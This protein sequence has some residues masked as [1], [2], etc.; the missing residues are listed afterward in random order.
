MKKRNFF[1]RM[2]LAG[3]VVALLCATATSNAL[4]APKT[5]PTCNGWADTLQTVPAYCDPATQGPGYVCTSGAATLCTDF[6]GKGNYAN[7][8]LPSGPIDTTASGFT[9]VHGGSGY[10]SPVAVTVTDYFTGTVANP[11]TGCLASVDGNGTITGITCATAGSGYMAPVVSIAGAGGSGSGA[12]VDAK[13]SAAGPLVGGIRKFQDNLPDL[14]GAVASPD[15]TTFPGSDYYE[16]ALVKTTTQMHAD[17]PLTPVVGYVQFPSGSSS[18]S[19]TPVK[20]YQY[21]GP[22]ILAQKDKPVRVKFTNCLTPGSG[23]D[24]FIPVD[25]TYMGAGAGPTT[26]STDPFFCADPAN[27]ASCFQQNRATLHLHGGNTPWISDGTPHQW[28]VPYGDTSATFKRGDSTQFVP[29]MFFDATGKVSAVP[30]PQCS[31]AITTNCYPNAPPAGL[32]SDPGLG[33]MTFYWTNQQGGRLMFYHDHA[34][35]TTRLN[36]YAGEAAGYLVADP[37]QE[38]KLKLLNVPGTIT[39]PANPADLVNN[40]L[41]HLIP[42][43]IQ[44]KTFVPSAPQLL[45]Q[46]PTWIWGTG[47]TAVTTGNGN[48]VNGDL[49]FPHVYPPNQNPND[50]NGGPNNPL[51]ANGFG[52]WDYGVWFVPGQNVLS[53]AGTGPLGPNTAVTIP[54]TSS[55]FPGVLLEPTEANQYQGGCPI[56][57]NPSGTPEGFMDTPLV[58]GKAYPVLNVNPEAYRFQILSAGNDRSWNLQLYAADATGNDVAMLPAATPPLNGLPLC[59]IINQPTQPG[60]GMGLTSAILDTAGEPINGTGLL[61]NCWP[62]YGQSPGIPIKQFHWPDDGR[63][64]GVP[65]PRQAGPAIVQIAT[66]GGLLPA[67]VVIPS[68]PVNY[69][70]NTRSV[71]I[72]NISTHGLWIGPAERA[73]V[74]IDFSKFAGKTLILYNDAPAPAPAFDMRLDYFTGAPDETSTGGAPT[75]LPGYGPNTRTVMK[76]VVGATGTGQTAFKVAPLAAPTGLPAL[77][78]ATQPTVVVPEPAYPAGAGHSAT[79]NYVQ[80][81]QATALTFQS[82]GPTAGTSVVAQVKVTPNGSGYSSST[83]V[84]ID[85]PACTPAPGTCVTALATP[86]IGAGGAIIGINV[87]NV[88]AGYAASVPNVVLTDHGIGGTALLPTC[89]GSGQSACGSGASAT[90]IMAAR[91]PFD[92][93]AIQE[94]FTL[95]YGRMNATLGT[96]IPFT[97]FNNQ[98]TLPFGYTDWATEIVQKDTPQLWYL[99]HNGVDTHFIHFHL[100]NVQV[101]NR[102]GWDGTVRPIDQNELGWKDTV[103]MNPLENVLLAIKPITPVVPFPVPD[104]IRL[105]DPTKPAGTSPDMAISGID[106]ATGNALANGQVNQEVNFGWEYVWH[107][108]ILGHEEN[109]MMR[110]MIYQVPPS[111]PANLTTNSA[112]QLTWTDNSASESAFILQKDTVNTFNSGALATFTVTGANSTGF[113]TLGYGQT[114]T[115]L[116]ASASCTPMYYRVQAQD[117]FLPQSPLTATPGTTFQ[118]ATVASDWTAPVL[119]GNAPVSITTASLPFG[120]AGTAYNATLAAAGGSGPYTWAITAGK[121]AWLSINS[122]TGALTG[123]PPNTTGSPFTLA[124]QVTDNCGVVVSKNLSLTVYPPLSITTS[125]L[126]AGTVNTLYTTTTLTATGGSGTYVNWAV[127]GGALPAGLSLNATTGAISGTPTAP[128]NASITFQVT[129]SIGL[130]ATRSLTLTVNWPAVVITPATLRTAEVSNAS[131]NP[132]YAGATLAAT[133]GN[134]TYTW[135]ISGGALPGGLTLSSAGVISG[136]VGSSVA[137]NSYN[138]TARASSGSAPFT[139]TSTQSFSI[140]VVSHVAINNTAMPQGAVNVAYPATQLAATGGVAPIA[141]ANPGGGMPPGIGISSTGLISGTPTASGTFSFTVQVTD[142]LAGF[143]GIATRQVTITIGSPNGGVN[144]TSLTFA[145]QTVGT[146]SAAQTAT[147]SNSVAATAPLSINAISISGD[148]SQTNTCGAT[149]A[150]GASCTFSVRFTPTAVGARAGSLSINTNNSGTPTLTVALSGTGASA[151]TLPGAPTNLVATSGTLTGGVYVLPVGQTSVFLGWAPP[152]APGNTQT[153]YNIQRFSGGTWS[154]IGTATATATTFRVTGLVAGTTYTYRIQA[155]NAAGATN[156]ATPSQVQVQAR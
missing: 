83:T 134:G 109:D 75:T 132:V 48:L 120:V 122:A 135:T 56:I 128:A 115:F 65:D 123:T 91:V 27:E 82:T 144:P 77:F 30:V 86:K 93:K 108:H 31:A 125:T 7:S 89:G 72:T 96:E 2:S 42:L 141:W 139:V 145:S 87:T 16:I 52:R 110:P 15:V 118:T 61:G 152:A 28:T 1:Q 45:A 21:L 34:L 54:C 156:C 154:T 63:D 46:D 59:T 97:N 47:T 99:Y 80:N 92:L 36:V 124:V 136:T 4:A 66:E 49:W 13:L 76:I 62:S 149:L 12:W 58:N 81:F 41:A 137:P 57:P 11:A 100:F 151:V 113:S 117:D 112:G 73:D 23:G 95:D 6:Y 111:I 140:T 8:P 119:I 121:P 70:E 88:G 153:S 3:A 44:D 14:K 29:D 53:A 20:P 17:L 107:C 114:V 51:G 138:F 84:A 67:P 127:T 9:I 33:S 40:D 43:V 103:R 22:I 69:E 55:A 35:G 64:G 150:A 78:A 129:D 85:P 60:L 98:T 105:Q 79:T 26:P 126:P 131:G 104:S 130:T 90:A 94:L 18:C 10:V 147:L 148:Y 143:P 25:T 32:S 24:L 68:T 155:V 146:T 37:A 39:N 71:T 101:I 133:G 102:I 50:L 74:I 19:A 38:A 106:P 116:G 142:S 5:I